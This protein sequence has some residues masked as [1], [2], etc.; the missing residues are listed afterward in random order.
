MENITQGIAEIF[1]IKLKPG[2]GAAFHK[3]YTEQSLPLQKQW[4]VALLAYGPSLH[5][6]DVYWVVRQY[7]DLADR[8][9]SQDAFYESDDWKRGPREEILGLIESYTAIV[10]PANTALL[11]GFRILNV[12]SND[13]D[14]QGK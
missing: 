10:V 11:N 6:E 14:S 1:C 3:L 7:K 9:Q 2:T 12:Q 8:Q 4:K 5:D 13:I